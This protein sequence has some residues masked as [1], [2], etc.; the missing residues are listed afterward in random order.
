M[1][2]TALT[3]NGTVRGIPGADPRITAFKGIPFAKPPV[4]KL[5]WRAPEPAEDW[6]GVLDCSRFA[7]ISMQEIPGKDPD[8]IY[9]REWHVDPEIPMSEDCLYLNV[10][11]PARTGEERYPVMVWFFGGG[12][13]C[14]YTAEMEF[15]GERIARRGIVLVSVNYRVGVFGFLTHPELMEEDP[16]GCY[17]NYGMLDQRAGLEWVQKNIGRFGGDPENVT[18]FG[19]SAGAG[20]V[21]CQLTSPMNAG[22]G[23]FHKAIFQSG[24]G[25]RA[26]GQGN[27][28]LTLKE[29]E[30]NGIGFF[31]KNGLASLKQARD[32][33]AK[34][35][36]RMG[37]DFGFINKWS[38]T[39]DGRFLT[40]DPSDA[41]AAGRY[42]DIPLLF[43]CTGGEYELR[44]K[45]APETVEDLE[46]FAREKFGDEWEEF[47]RLCHADTDDAVRK[48][49]YS[50]DAFKGRVMNNVLFLWQRMKAGYDGNYMYYFNP[51]IPGW[52]HPGAFHSSELW[53]MF[54][55][56]AKCWRPFTGAHYDLARKMCNYWTNFARTGNPNG[57]DQDKTEMPE[58]KSST[59]DEPFILF[60]GEKYIG[61][62]ENCISELTKFRMR[63]VFER[64]LKK[65]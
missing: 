59:P 54:E 52:D 42:P 34:T 24:G 46:R 19:Q 56:L 17:G 49:T 36:C 9:T 1:L 13:N 57:L 4:G 62:Y 65:V 64:L 16:D 58:W 43:G 55:T 37:I 61:K 14:G 27:F 21:I 47:L 2:R 45:P 39:V 22:K 29:A 38:P 23:L 50:D 53:F 60:L 31:E 25:L 41:L 12:F 20:S 28:M 15:D 35:I 3:E 7:P 51:E 18:I 33:D 26:Y 44:G 11:T 32:T 48:L 63:Y 5:R 6:E 40:E 10:W 30:Q 8:N